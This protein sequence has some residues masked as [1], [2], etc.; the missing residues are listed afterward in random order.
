VRVP[1]IP[2]TARLGLA[3][4]RDLVLG[5]LLDRLAELNGDRLLVEEPGGVRWT[6]VEAAERVRRWSGT[7]AARVEHGDRVVIATANG[8]DQLLACFAVSRAGALPVPVNPQLTPSELDHIIADSAAALVVRDTDTLDDASVRPRDDTVAAEPGDVAALF[9][10]SGT[11]GAPKG[12][13]LTHRALVGEVGRVAALPPGVLRL[14]AVLGLPVAHIMGFYVLVAFA[15]AAIPVYLL[16]R[17]N[18]VTVLDAIEDRRPS[19]FVGVPAMYRMLL[20]AGAEDRDLSSIRVWGSGAD[21]MPP[22]LA[23]RF[24][25]MGAAA[26]LPLIGRPVGQATFVEGYGM[27]E[28]GG[29]AVLKISL[30][31]IDRG[32][33]ST[34][35]GFP[36]PGYRLRVLDPDTG[37]LAG[38]GHSGELVL[39]GPG[40]TTGYWG[41]EAASRDVLTD[42]GWLRTGDLA[43]LGPLGTVVF[44]GRAKDV[45]KR[46]GYSIYALEVERAI[47]THPDVLEASVVAVPDERLGEVPAA[48]VRLREGVELDEAALAAHAGE[49]LAA[50]KVPAHWL[51]VDELPRT[52]TEKVRKRELVS[53]F[54]APGT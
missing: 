49:H 4:R 32:M 21:A 39:R 29:G 3:R 23:L 1:R 5:S 44:E 45:V 25:R 7:V 8:Y 24:K 16:P 20:E 10:T 42:D 34:A 22:E 14:D 6:Y 36:L 48:A 13:E 53:R 15:C 27:V 40:V 31:G 30:P 2:G 41:D 33:G 19:I 47:E 11:T 38:K 9:Y 37:E 35:L 28:T 52:A 50:Y 26:T 43:R 18:P 17:F 46:G 12:V 54:T 51:A